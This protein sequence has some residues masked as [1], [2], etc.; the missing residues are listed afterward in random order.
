M[1]FFLLNT[2]CKKG[3]YLYRPIKISNPKAPLRVLAPFFLAIDPVNM[4]MDLFFSGQ[5]N[6]KP[7][8]RIIFFTFIYSSSTVGMF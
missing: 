6:S 1:T 3:A 4:I 8:F 7:L 5:K 2:K